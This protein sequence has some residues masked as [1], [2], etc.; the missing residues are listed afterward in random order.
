[1]LHLEHSFVWR[2]TLDTSSSKSEISGK[3]LNAVLEKKRHQLV[4]SC[5]KGSITKGQGG[6]EYHTKNKKKEG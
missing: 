4:R 5:E 1:M 6:E 2:L 3:F